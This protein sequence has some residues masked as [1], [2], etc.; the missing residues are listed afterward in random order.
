MTT[1]A[2]GR[3]ARI[4]LALEA[5][6]WLTTAWLALDMLPGKTYRKLLMRTVTANRG[7]QSVEFIGQNRQLARIAWAVQRVSDRVPFRSV[8]F[9][10]GIAAQQMLKRRGIASM[11]HYG[12]AKT[13]EGRVLQAHVWVSS[14]GRDVIGGE[15]KNGFQEIAFFPQES[16]P[17]LSSNK[18]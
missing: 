7:D 6:A 5:F 18:H 2:L 11:L 10:R 13:R 8:C 16:M 17:P 3:V 1:L 14:D 15:A 9:H 12:V 4:A